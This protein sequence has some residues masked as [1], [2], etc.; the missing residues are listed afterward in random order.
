MIAID[1][2]D[3]DVDHLSDI[4]AVKRRSCARCRSGVSDTIRIHSISCSREQRDILLVAERVVGK[5][6]RRSGVNKE[7]GDKLD[8]EMNAPSA[9][10]VRQIT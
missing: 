2:Q 10:E 3:W 9:G 4:R 7:N 1:M 6:A 8:N 5:L